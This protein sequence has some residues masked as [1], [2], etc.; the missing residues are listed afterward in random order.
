MKQTIL[1]SYG[2]NA[3]GFIKVSKNVYKVKTSEG[4]YALKMVESQSV[5]VSYEHIRTL[6]LQCFV[7]IIKNNNRTILTRFE[8]CYFYLMPWLENDQ[9]VMK[10]IKLKY[11]FESLAYIH[12]QSF[13]NYNVSHSYFDQQVEDIMRIIDEREQYYLSIMT[14]YEAM[15]QKTPSGWIFVLNYY[16]MMEG[17][18]KARL[19]L[20]KYVEYTKDKDTIRLSLVYNNFNY[21]HVLMG[22]RK[23]IAI[24]KVDIDI[25]I[26]D[27]YNMYQKVPELLFD[28][29]GISMYYLSK[30]KLL[31]EEKLLLSC[32]LCIVP[33]IE[34]EKDEIRNIVKISRLLYYLDS[35]YTLIEQLSID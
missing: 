17:L 20:E 30:V 22:E 24:D 19:Y 23:L 14:N 29:D 15:Q 33:Y 21:Q 8:N 32:L 4:F 12:N 35:I 27:I 26:Y 11:Y 25:C 2:I 31:P 13:F 10:E 1:D 6:H 7:I 3:I 5:E 28:L 18:Q 16:R 9:V 34:I